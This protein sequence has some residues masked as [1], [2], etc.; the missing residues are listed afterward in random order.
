[1]METILLIILRQ[2]HIL[3][4]KFFLFVW[5]QYFKSWDSLE[6]KN[7]ILPSSIS[8]TTILPWNIMSNA[9]IKF[10]NYFNDLLIIVYFEHGSWKSFNVN[11]RFFYFDIAIEISKVFWFH[12]HTFKYGDETKDSELFVSFVSIVINS[13]LLDHFGF[14]SVDPFFMN[15]D[16]GIVIL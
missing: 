5:I 7:T 4:I 12:V 8:L 15:L 3:E 14:D 6:D 10:I 16:F 9:L 1:M 13:E 2:K 11:I